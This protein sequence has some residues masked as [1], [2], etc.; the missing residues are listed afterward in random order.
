M[1]TVQNTVTDAA[2]NP[3]ADAVIRIDLIAGSVI[4]QPGYTATTTIGPPLVLNAD[5][6][7][8]WSVTL[9][10]NAA[11]TPASTYYRINEAGFVSYAVV[12]ASGGPYSLPSILVT[13]ASPA[14]PAITGV[15]V[16]AD[17][18]VA[19]VRPEVNFVS[20]SNVAI[21]AADN[22]G[23]G[24][25]D[26]TIAASG[27]GGGGIPSDTVT[28]GTS[29]GLASAPGT[30]TTYSRGDHSH[31]TPAQ[32][33]SPTYSG[34]VT[35]ARVITPPVALT[36]AATI[37]TDA[38]TGAHFRVTLGGNRTLGNPTSPA[39]GQRIIWELIQDATGGR[40]LTLD[41]AFVLGTDITAV[42]L[43]TAAGKRDFLGAVY[44]AT[45]GK[46]Y[47]VALARGF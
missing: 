1:P 10:G 45:A 11:I 30:S 44:N 27:S 4:A 7:G 32:P 39:D 36:D 23:S 28:S 5:P 6:T 3:V 34:T 37:A 2:G 17:G 38:S 9:T 13:P 14:S 18:T 16:A 22:P 21:A 25:I 40:T 24:R 8:H 29:Y 35:A 42:T 12:P 31:G 43:S 19:G 41:T 47:V 33:T 46:W 26:V 20:G 15:Q